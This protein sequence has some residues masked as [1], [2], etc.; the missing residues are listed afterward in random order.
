MGLGGV[1]P[2]VRL[3]G[4][5]TAYGVGLCWTWGMWGWVVWSHSEAVLAATWASAAPGDQHLHA[6]TACGAGYM[7]VISS[8]VKGWHC[9]STA[10]SPSLHAP[11]LFLLELRN[12]VPTGL[13]VNCCFFQDN[14]GI[15]SKRRGDLAHTGSGRSFRV[16]LVIPLHLLCGN[17]QCAG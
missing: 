17:G 15:W 6:E 13:N 10:P 7:S 5:G 14:P 16:S 12:A 8:L 3:G 1:G 9:P 4:C 2:A 11:S